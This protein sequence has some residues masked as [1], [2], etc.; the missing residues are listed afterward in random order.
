MSLMG[1][2][3]GTTGTKAIVFDTEGNVL[4]SAYREY[5]LQSP[6]AGWLQLDPNEVWNKVKAA[7]A[8]AAAES[9]D[10][11]QALAISCLGES[12]VPLSK[13]GEVLYPTIV[14]FD[15]RA[16]TLCE[17]WLAGQ[18]AQEIM[19]ITGMPPSQMYTM[20]KLMWLKENEPN[21][22]KEIWKYVCYEDY[23]IWRMGL[24][25]TIDYSLASRTMA[26]DVRGKQWSERMCEMAGVDVSVWSEA[27]ASGTIVGELSAS[28]AEELGLPKGCK[29]V[30]GGHD[31]PAGAVGAGVV[32]GGVSVDATGTVECFALAM[33]DPVLNDAMRESNFCCYPHVAHNLYISLA[34]NLTGGSLLKWYRDNFAQEE[35]RIAEQRGVDVYD[36][37]MEVMADEPT[38]LFVQPHFTMTGTP[39]FDADPVGAIVGLSLTTT[40]AQLIKAIVEG[41]TWEMK[42]NLRLLEDAGATV[43]ELRAIGGGAKSDKWLQLKADMFNKPVAKLTTSEA[44]ALGDVIAA[45]VAIGEYASFNEA[46]KQ[47]V[48]PEKVF[49]PQADRSAFYEERIEKYR[50]LYPSLRLWKRGE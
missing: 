28:A 2:D 10:P 50:A 23:A 29:V 34:F 24:P 18:D 3:I 47:L 43:N 35:A 30:T 17:R 33:S 5:S 31:Q 6:R 25:P 32:E 41:I 27:V 14:G 38:E 21:V 39:Y 19:S 42:L 8:E 7:V 16:M 26:F 22:Y 45:G 36:V 1:L 20:I 12:A 11:V 13:T 9:S 15:N 44:A 49:E 48:R 37:L 46:V 4:A 40:K